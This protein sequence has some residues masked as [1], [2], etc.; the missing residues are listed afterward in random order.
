MSSL[1]RTISR[2]IKRNIEP[3]KLA[4]Q[5]LAV[6]GNAAPTKQPR[7]QDPRPNNQREREREGRERKRES[8]HEGCDCILCRLDKRVIA[9][10]RQTLFGKKE[11]EEVVCP[12][13]EL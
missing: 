3:R 9:S 6:R 4:L 5:T 12:A 7:Q 11:K 10:T 2:A 1:G 8:R 13:E